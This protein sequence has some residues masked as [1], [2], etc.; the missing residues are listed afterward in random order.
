M[1]EKKSNIKLMVK[2]GI[3]GVLL[4]LML[5]PL[6]FIKN[7]MM[8]RKGYKA[9]AF[10]TI[11]SSWGGD[12]LVAAPFLNVPYSYS[13]QQTDKD[14]NVKTIT[15]TGIYKVSP[16]DLNVDV[17]LV[18]QIRY[19]G[20]FEMPVYTADI[21][22]KGNFGKITDTPSDRKLDLAKAFITLELTDVKGIV[23][24]PE[25]NF[26]GGALDFAP[27]AVP[28]TVEFSGNLGNDEDYKG[29]ADAPRSKAYAA[30][31]YEYSR[32][33]ST[34]LKAIFSDVNYA[35]QKG[36]FDIKFSLRG[37]GSINFVPSA[38]Q[39]KFNVASTWKDPLFFN[40]FLPSTKTI[41]NDGF[42]AEW[43]ISYLASGIPQ[44]FE[45]L[46]VSSAIFG[47]K[48]STPV[49]NYRNGLRAAKY[50]ILFVALTFLACFVFEMVGK[51]SIHPF[52][53]TLVGLAM[54]LFYLL[55]ISFSEFIGFGWAYII[56]SAAVVLMISLYIRYGVIKQGGWKYSVLPGVIIAAL[57]AYLY[58]LLQLQDFSAL[59]GAIGL[60]VGLGVV[61]YTTRNINWYE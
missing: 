58:I 29:T 10:K 57:Y 34:S 41:N 27:Y 16:R 45:K 4:L 13:Y 30:Y 59:F 19:I 26:N 36:E 61:M 5:I 39:N 7:I 52:Q 32:S 24:M 2:A 18:P 31:D 25:G 21:S 47:V 40:S 22:L 23:K 49:D 14:K 50:G 6:A 46:D 55:L 42:T 44:V 60:F 12:Q 51:S 28:N 48:L 43:D 11:S 8:E 35:N 56:A 38:K 17:N 3:I 9:E 37:S 33:S 20:I 53:Y 54:A 1:A 15:V